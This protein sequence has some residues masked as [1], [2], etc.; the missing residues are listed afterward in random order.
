MIRR[1]YLAT[2]MALSTL[3]TPAAIGT[4][5]VGPALVSSALVGSALVGP[6]LGGPAM[7]QGAKVNVMDY[8]LA[9]PSD[10]AQI[11]EP[12]QLGDSVPDSV[13]LHL[14]DDGTSAY[15][16]F[17]YAGQPVIVD[18]KTRSVVRIGN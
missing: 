10:N 3:A 1:T 2:V 6:A 8:A 17:Y 13:T 15:G 7:A 5:L 11:A 16:Y 4:G 18:M 14:P 12:P 9:H